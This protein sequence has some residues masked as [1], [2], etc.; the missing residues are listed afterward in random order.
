[1]ELWLSIVGFLVVVGIIVSI[2]TK[3]RTSSVKITVWFFSLSAIFY[4]CCNITFI[5]IVI[6]IIGKYFSH[7]YNHMVGFFD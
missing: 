5:I 3:K 7:C 1:M 6:N 4:H 2:M